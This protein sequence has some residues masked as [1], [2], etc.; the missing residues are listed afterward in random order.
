MD[1]EMFLNLWLVV[2]TSEM[3]Q[4]ANESMLDLNYISL[5]WSAYE[6]V[7]EDDSGEDDSRDQ[8]NCADR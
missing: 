5:R 8:Q 3:P 7:W 1:V 6:L 4:Y 2:S